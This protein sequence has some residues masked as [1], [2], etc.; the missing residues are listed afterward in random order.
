MIGRMRQS[1]LRPLALAAAGVLLVALDFRVRAADL[2]PDPVGWVLV[3][4]AAASSGLVVPARWA[5]AAAVL[6]LSDFLLPYRLVAIDPGTGIELRAAADGSSVSRV[7]LW[8]RVSDVRALVMAAAVAAGSMALVTLVVTV[9]RRASRARAVQD[10]RW[11][12][13]AGGAAV[14][15]WGVPYLVVALAAV[16]SPRRFD[17]VWNGGLEYLAFAGVG[18]LVVFA[19]VLVRL[20]DESWAV[21]GE[22]LYASRWEGRLTGAPGGPDPRG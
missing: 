22:G 7:L 1:P 3:A 8:D 20:R 11:L 21:P 17:P 9:C 18:A 5:V 2:V 15:V 16:G 19:G 10:A 4:L 6:S 13:L 12:G 14:A